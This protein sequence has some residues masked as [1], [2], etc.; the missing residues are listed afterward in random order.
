[1]GSSFFV[2]F[3]RASPQW[4]AEARILK[5]DEATAL[6]LPPSTVRCDSIY[7]QINILHFKR[8]QDMVFTIGQFEQMGNLSK[9]AHGLQRQ[10]IGILK[11]KQVQSNNIPV[12]RTYNIQRKKTE[13]S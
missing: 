4:G 13:N 3:R 9:W 2:V 11:N 10:C 8:A 1:M 12:Y 7:M 6:S 5:P